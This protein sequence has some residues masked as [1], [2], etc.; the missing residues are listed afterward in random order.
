MKRVEDF[1]YAMRRT[2]LGDLTMHGTD[3]EILS[4]QCG[5]DSVEDLKRILVSKEADKETLAS[6]YQISSAL[7]ILNAHNEVEE[8]DI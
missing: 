4:I 7:D 2:I 5:Y 6:L 8:R 1:C 3:L